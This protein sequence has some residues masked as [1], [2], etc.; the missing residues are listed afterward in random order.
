MRSRSRAYTHSIH[1]RARARAHTDS[2]P[3]DTSSLMRKNLSGR[4]VTGALDW[5]LCAR[6]SAAAVT[7]IAFVPVL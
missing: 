7:V 1:Q 4:A 3:D 6:K 5:P 2:S